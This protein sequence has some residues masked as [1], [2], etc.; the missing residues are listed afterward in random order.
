M[1]KLFLSLALVASLAGLSSCGGDEPY[2]PEITQE[3]IT[4]PDLINSTITIANNSVNYIE[5]ATYGFN[6][7]YTDMREATVEVVANNVKFDSHMPF[8]VSFA[9][10]KIKTYKLNDDYVE[11]QASTVKF[12]KPGTDEENTRYKLTNVRGYIDKRNKVYT[13]DYTV[14]DTWRVL[15]C[16]STISSRV[17]NNLYKSTTDLYY[18]YDVDITTMKAEVF[19]QNV[20]FNV[21]GASSPVLKKISIPN[22]DVV[23][24]STGFELS[25]DN[26]IPN[27]YSGAELDIPTP[28]PPMTVTNY[29]GTLNIAEGTHSIFFN[30]MGG[31][32]NNTSPLYLWSWKNGN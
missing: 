6:I 9:M 16:N 32:H 21:G 10:D 28:M 20:Q 11:F 29:H 27:N 7:E 4:A 12:L 15:V 3:T 2:V 17:E 25:G 24:T 23:A 22:L 30:S 31:E 1:K 13:L 5:T 8:P 14:N 19:I 18:T 26:I